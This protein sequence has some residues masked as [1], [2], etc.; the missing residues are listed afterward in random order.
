[1]T[2]IQSARQYTLKSD[3]PQNLRAE[4]WDG[5]L[6]SI[7]PLVQ[8]GIEGIFAF[9]DIVNPEKMPDDLL[10]I[11]LAEV[12][13]FLERDLPGLVLSANEK[14]KL[15]RYAIPLHKQKGSEPGIVNIIRIVLGIEVTLNSFNF[16]GFILDESELDVDVLFGG[17]DEEETYSFE[18]VTAEEPSEEVLAKIEALARYMKPIYMHLY[19]VTAPEEI[20]HLELDMSVL[21]DDDES[22]LH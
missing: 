6:D 1:M 9:V 3:W 4:D 14:R 11:S 20:D 2:E 15:L 16:D 21:D 8:E 12:G 22:L 13:I 19:R 17:D 10:D 18:I 7:D 5:V